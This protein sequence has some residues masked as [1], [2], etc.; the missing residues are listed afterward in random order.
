MLMRVSHIIISCNSLLVRLVL[1]QIIVFLKTLRD[2]NRLIVKLFLGQTAVFLKTLYDLRKFARA[3]FHISFRVAI[4]CAQVLLQF[5]F[6]GMVADALMFAYPHVPAGASWALAVAFAAVACPVFGAAF[7]HGLRRCRWNMKRRKCGLRR[8]CWKRRRRRI[9]VSRYHAT[10][11]MRFELDRRCCRLRGGG[12]LVAALQQL[13]ESR[14]FNETDS[15]E[16]A[17]D[18]WLREQLHTMLSQKPSAGGLL[19]GLRRVL[20]QADA[21]EQSRQSHVPSQSRWNSA[22]QRQPKQT[23]TWNMRTTATV[24]APSASREVTRWKKPKEAKMTVANHG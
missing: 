2:L 21:W 6:T 24:Q 15:V 20:Q 18:A 3:L 16:D 14:N 9:L 22:R 11:R 1:G 23:H 7:V 5:C 12:G 17:N 13:L 10:T 8:L 4:R 19:A